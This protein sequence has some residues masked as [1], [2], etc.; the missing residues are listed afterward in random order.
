M[1]VL[2]QHA[3]ECLWVEIFIE[4]PSAAY[5]AGIGGGDSIHAR[6]CINLAEMRGELTGAGRTRGVERGGKRVGARVATR[7]CQAQIE[8]ARPQ[9]QQTRVQ[10]PFVNGLLGAVANCRHTG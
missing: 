10:Q 7:Q 6:R 1:L 3:Q 8:I 5:R 9:F 4:R 2:V